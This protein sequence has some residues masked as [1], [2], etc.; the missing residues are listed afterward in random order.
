MEL[1]AVNK[2]KIAL[3]QLDL[4]KFTFNTKALKHSSRLKVTP[5]HTALNGTYSDLISFTAGTKQQTDQ[6]H[7][8]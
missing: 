4:G 1:Y 7:N 6:T 3:L 5:E 8:M 2:L